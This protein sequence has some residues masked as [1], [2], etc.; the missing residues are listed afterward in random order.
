MSLVCKD[1]PFKND[2]SNNND[3]SWDNRRARLLL[4]RATRLMCRVH[5]GVLVRSSMCMHYAG[6]LVGHSVL[7]S[8]SISLR[9]KLSLPSS[10]LGV[11]FG[12]SSVFTK[13]RFDWLNFKASRRDSPDWVKDRSMRHF[14][15]ARILSQFEF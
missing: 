11:V 10:S 12:W 5:N 13:D 3:F 8:L 9:E 14:G 15:A 4:T 7:V 6:A 2:D 1:S